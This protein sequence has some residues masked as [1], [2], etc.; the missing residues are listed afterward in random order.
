MKRAFLVVFALAVLV[1]ALVYA[2]VI[3]PK[4]TGLP[5]NPAS[6]GTSTK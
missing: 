3:V 2:G 5:G 4:P 6:K 1:L